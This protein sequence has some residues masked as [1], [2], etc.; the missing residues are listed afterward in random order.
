MAIV[1]LD[2]KLVK[3]NVWTRDMNNEI[4]R[5]LNISHPTSA[6]PH[7][8]EHLLQLVLLVALL[9]A[10]PRERH[11]QLGLQLLHGRRV[12]RRAKVLL[13]FLQEARTPQSQ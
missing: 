2:E 6:S 9:L 5:F 1:I 4:F 12:F 8:V 7:L 3:D 10:H 11:L 13:V